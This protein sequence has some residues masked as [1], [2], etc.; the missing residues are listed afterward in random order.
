M[1]VK[2]SGLAN[3]VAIAGA[4]DHTLALRGDGTVWAWGDNEFG[5][6]GIGTTT[7]HSTPVQVQS[8]TNIVAIAG[9]RDHSL[10]VRSDGTVWSWGWNQYGQVGDGTK[11]NNRL[12]PVQVT[13]LTGVTRVSAGADHSMALTAAGVVWAWG[14]N[15]DGQL[16]DGTAT[17]RSKPVSVTGVSGIVEIG[18]GRL[19]S[20]AVESDGSAWAWGLNSTG[21]LGD[22][23]TTNRRTP[24]KIPGI[25]GAFGV[26]GGV[27]YSV[28]LRSP[29]RLPQGGDEAHAG[30]GGR[31][32][33]RGP[34]KL[35][36]ETF[37]RIAAAAVA[38]SV[39]AVIAVVRSA[40]ASAAAPRASAPCI[41]STP[42]AHHQHVILIVEENKAYG[43]VMGHAPYQTAVAKAC[44]EASNMHAETYPS[45]PNYMAMT[46][47]AVPAPVVG[48][49]CQPAGGCTTTSQSIF[50]Q[51][52]GSWR[53]YAE[54]MPA[55]C[56]RANTRDGLYVPRHTAAPYY[57]D[58]AGACLKRQLPLG[59]T[60]SGALSSDLRAGT[61]ASFSLVVRTRPT[62]P[63]AGASRAPMRG[64]P[65][66]SRASSRHPPTRTGRPA[67]S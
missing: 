47:G 14:Q 22:G 48:R 64:W 30:R 56:S 34:M 26:G 15:N 3:V 40:T 28:V 5:N 19:H 4:R 49:D 20:L 46:S 55:N 2:V 32:A 11:G 17:N 45:L 16:G 67:C 62:T 36:H 38:L 57:T 65:A 8:L 29:S 39:L 58:L 12:R 31:A 61:L 44:G 41:G 27:N 66:G 6:L 52:A 23:T 33:A 63:T 25:S 1:P 10:A 54:S 24:V 60:T 51:T 53:V 42:P 18:N 35:A 37:T 13:G 7:N 21:Q 59:T 9:G 50:A 43:Q